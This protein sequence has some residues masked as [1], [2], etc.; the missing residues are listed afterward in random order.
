VINHGFDPEQQTIWVS[1]SSAFF[2]TLKCQLRECHSEINYILKLCRTCS[3]TSCS[4]RNMQQEKCKMHVDLHDECFFTNF[5]CQAF[6]MKNVFET[7]WNYFPA[8]EYNCSFTFW[9]TS[10]TPALIYSGLH[11]GDIHRHAYTFTIHIWW[12]YS[13]TGLEGKREDYQ[14]CSVLY[15]VLKLFTLRWAVLTV[16][17]IGFVTLGP[18]H[19]A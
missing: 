5:Y 15:C 18:F 14:N 17:W 10:M 3:A 13:S 8:N 9:V 7:L 6:I 1:F 4:T 11:S 12:Y 16:L 2:V 19:C